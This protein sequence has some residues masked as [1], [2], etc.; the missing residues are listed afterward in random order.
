MKTPNEYM[1]NIKNRIITDDMLEGCLYSVNKRAKNCRDKVR[2]YKHILMQS[3]YHALYMGN[4]IEKYEQ[5]REAYYAKKDRILSILEPTCIHIERYYDDYDDDPIEQAYLFFQ[6]KDHSFHHPI[7]CPHGAKLK[8]WVAKKYPNLPI[9][10]IEEPLITFGDDPT[11]LL[12]C[13]FVNMV[14]SL[15]DSGNYVLEMDET[16]INPHLSEKQEVPYGM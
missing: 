4:N 7:E 14:L 9:V 2:E 10:E 1:R 12:S 11:A 16:I 13:N 6:F 15:I 3:N 8:K 5:K